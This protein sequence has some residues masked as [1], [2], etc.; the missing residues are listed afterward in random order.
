MEP[1]FGVG[2]EFDG[3]H[4][5][6]YID[7]GRSG[8]VWMVHEIAAPKNVWA[9]KIHLGAYV[10]V[11]KS[12]FRREVKFVRRDYI[13]E[14][15]P[16]FIRAG[17][18]N[19][20]LYYMT[21]Y[22]EPLPEEFT[23]RLVMRVFLPIARALAAL[24]RLG[25][26]HC[27]LKPANIVLVNGVPKL[28]DF[29]CVTTIRAAELKPRCVGTRGY[30]PPEV[31][32]GMLLNVRAEVCAFGYLL[33]WACRSARCR[34]TFG[35]LILYLTNHEPDA[36][37]ASMDYVCAKLPLCRDWL[38]RLAVILLYIFGTPLLLAIAGI[39]V[40]EIFEARFEKRV[41]QRN[42]DYIRE[43]AFRI[44]AEHIMKANENVR[45]KKESSEGTP[46]PRDAK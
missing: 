42:R 12:R 25:F 5:D 39:V 18:W 13:R 15:R 16:K 38:M 44:T 28:I 27:D 34:R 37:P 6:K 30:T 7:E 17:C 35:P 3:L 21:E 2:I 20:H 31:R 40:A 45:Q 32:E 10:N 46:A 22:G 24:H 26:L 36:R 11:R 33:H 1:E 29:G 19:G 9:V 41:E 14:H 43:N 23:P 4:V 8:S